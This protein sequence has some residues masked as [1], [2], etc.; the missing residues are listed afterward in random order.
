MLQ[1]AFIGID[2][3]KARLDVA[4][5]PGGETLSVSN[6]TRGIAR[7]VKVVK[8]TEPKCVVLEATGGF[9]LMVLEKLS[10]S[11][12]PVVVVNPRQARQFARADGR[13]GM[14]D[15]ARRYSLS[16]RAPL[17]QHKKCWPARRMTRRPRIRNP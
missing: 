6:D 7:L 2:V 17:G 3:S 16:P 15:L 1:G 11:S 12:V 10:A 14:H 5:R 9:E 4:I 8:S 13:A